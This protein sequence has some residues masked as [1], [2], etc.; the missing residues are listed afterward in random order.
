MLTLANN[1]VLDFGAVGLRD[2]L[3]AAAQAGIATVGAGFS[4]TTARRPAIFVV[5]GLR[6]AFLGY[7]DINP[8]GFK[9][10]DTTPGTATATREALWSVAGP[11]L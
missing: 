6:V 8:L 11:P 9:A 7:S 4:S 3:A 1:H 10:T 5:G 2:T